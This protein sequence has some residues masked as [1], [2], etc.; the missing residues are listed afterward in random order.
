[1]KTLA[2][3]FWAGTVLAVVAYLRGDQAAMTGIVGAGIV[4]AAVTVLAVVER[5]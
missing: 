4:A 3:L 5:R 1:V 2:V